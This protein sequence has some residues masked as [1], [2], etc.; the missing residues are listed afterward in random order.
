[1]ECEVCKCIG[2]D[3]GPDPTRAIYMEQDGRIRWGNRVCELCEV[4]PSEIVLKGLKQLIASIEYLTLPVELRGK[5]EI[6]E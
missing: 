3:D 4:A 2:P 1:M 5:D 6:S